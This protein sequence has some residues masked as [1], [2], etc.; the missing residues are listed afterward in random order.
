MHCLPLHLEVR[1]RQGVIITPTPGHTK[2]HLD[3]LYVACDLMQDL[4]FLL[5][6]A[7]GVLNQLPGSPA[8]TFKS[9]PRKR[10]LTLNADVPEPWLVEAVEVR[11]GHR[12]GWTSIWQN[13]LHST[14]I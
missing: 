13:S 7:E 8:A 6:V 1:G 2:Y 10:V 3:V 14:A 12:T 11:G 5:L 9:L 4:S